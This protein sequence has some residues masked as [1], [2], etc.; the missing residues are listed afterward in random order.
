MKKSRWRS[1]TLSVRRSRA[2]VR[3]VSSNA[4]RSPLRCISACPS[5]WSVSSVA[6]SPLPPPRASRLPRTPR[7]PPRR[8]APRH[9]A[10]DDST[11]AS[12]AASA[13]AP[14]RLARR[15]RGPTVRRRA[16]PTAARGKQR[17]ARRGELDRQ[18]QPIESAADLRHRRRHLEVRIA[19]RGGYGKQLLPR[20]RVEW[21]DGEAVLASEF[22]RLT[23]G[24]E[25]GQTRRPRGKP[26]EQRCGG[27]NVLQVVD[28]E[29]QR[30]GA[31]EP[32]ER[33]LGGLVHEPLGAQPA[34]Q[35]LRHVRGTGTARRVRPSTPDRRCA[36]RRPAPA[37]SCRRPPVPAG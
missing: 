21:P 22:E 19:A 2:K 8:R 36:P 25:H 32:D 7:T 26:A 28:D 35:R 13:V 16:V 12:P 18:W 1:R 20:R 34:D 11:R 33:V 4:S 37:A 15:G 31:E 23:A 3:T 10:A 14:A 29:Q 17:R 5:A 6:R 9:R 30:L 27:Q 24:G